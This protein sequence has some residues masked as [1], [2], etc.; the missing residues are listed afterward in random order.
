M[1]ESA[2]RALILMQSSRWE[3]ARDELRRALLEDSQNP[4]LHNTLAI[5][6]TCLE[7]FETAEVHART[8]VGLAPDDSECHR[9]LAGVLVNRRKF[10][11][12]TDA[13]EQAIRLDAS[14]VEAFSTLAQIRYANDDWSG[15]LDASESG[16]ELEPEHVVCNNLRAIALV[17]L[18]RRA[19]AGQTLA[20]ALA[21]DP[22]DGL[23]HANQGWSLLESGQQDLAFE[24][25]RE[26]LALDP[27]SDWAR[28][29]IV[30]A[31]KS[32][33]VVYRYLLRYFLFMSRLSRTVLWGIMIGGYLLMRWLMSYA[34]SH[35]EAS[36]YCMTLVVAYAAFALLTWLGQPLFN[37]I[38]FTDKFGRRALSADQRRQAIC[39][40]G[41]LVTGSVIAVA[42]ALVSTS[43]L[44]GVV[45]KS[46]LWIA[47][48]S[49]PTV[50]IFQCAVGW[51]R[52]TALF[53]TLALGVLAI[54][55]MVV[56]AVIVLWPTAPA[57]PFLAALALSDLYV[58][59]LIGS[60][61]LAM[62]LMRATPER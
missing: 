22:N 20:A 12:A 26:A 5:C 51:P 53:A 36:P 32:R 23:T 40:G 33:N 37:L 57:S 50:A 61:F 10:A 29:G 60:Q 55:P 19:E 2:Q 6:L 17:K 25:F 7:D 3:L 4:Y 43:K 18:G 52:R 11:A 28:E 34:A 39:V 56:V 44:D 41:L 24:H 48:L 16:L 14:N 9:I 59:G 58:P 1:N 45:Y 8:A 31:L 30:E 13:V 62:W 54:I 46:A 42:T 38:L 15:L 49:L 47:L 21:K 35:P 27:E